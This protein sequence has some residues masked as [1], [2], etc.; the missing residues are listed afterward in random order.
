LANKGEYVGENPKSHFSN[1]YLK[2][3]RWTSDP[4]GLRCNWVENNDHSIGSA[5]L[6]AGCRI[7]LAERRRTGV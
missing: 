7:L 3:Q 6:L 4:A 5:D 1:T 2:D